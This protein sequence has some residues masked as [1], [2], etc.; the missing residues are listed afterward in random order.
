MNPAVDAVWDSACNGK[1]EGDT[2][3]AKCEDGH[4][5]NAGDIVFTCTAGT[6]VGTLSCTER[7]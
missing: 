2:C 4:E 1:V 5:A 3:N 6:F 7:N